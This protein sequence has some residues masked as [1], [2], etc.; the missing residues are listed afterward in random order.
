[1]PLIRCTYVVKTHGYLVNYNTFF[2]FDHVRP[3]RTT[4]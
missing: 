1:M 2:R 3:Y 4:G